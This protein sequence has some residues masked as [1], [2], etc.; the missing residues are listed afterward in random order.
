MARVGNGFL[1]VVLI[2]LFA[3]A[4]PAQSDPAPQPQRQTKSH[5]SRQ[6]SPD[7]AKQSAASSQP[8]QLGLAPVSTSEVARGAA[9][10]IAKRRPVSDAK[11]ADPKS[12][13]DESLLGTPDS[14]AVDEFKPAR[15]TGS[16][17]EVFVSKESKKSAGKNIHGT[18]YGSLDPTARGNHQT[19]GSVGATSKGGKTSVYV[20]TDSSRAVPSSH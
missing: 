10:E 9:R 14:S 12:K 7:T 11:P 2:L 19:S 16:T 5:A 17:D 3:A 15:R 8:A 13:T 18:A 4:L 20:E 1:L 6:S